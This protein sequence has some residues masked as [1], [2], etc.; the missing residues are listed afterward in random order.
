VTR[1][2]PV[3]GIGHAV[4]FEAPERVAELMVNFLR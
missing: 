3:P 2:E 1:L 4:Q